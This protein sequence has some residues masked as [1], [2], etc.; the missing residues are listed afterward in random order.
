MIDMKSI[1]QKRVDWSSL[2]L[3]PEEG[4]VLSRVDGASPVTVRELVALTGLDESRVL[5]ISGRPRAGGA[6]ETDG[7]G[8]LTRQ[9][10][11][12]RE[13]PSAIDHALLAF[14]NSE[15]LAAAEPVEPHE[16]TETDT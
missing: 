10:P 7:E 6:I 16:E 5:N 2:R 4:F 9:P 14:L 15:N 12:P 3:S 11:L 8:P 13:A 1:R